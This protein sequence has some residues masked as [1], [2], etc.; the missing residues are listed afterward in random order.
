M[1]LFVRTLAGR[2]VEVQALPSDTI[3]ELKRKIQ[4]KE[5]IPSDQQR[6]I[7]TG[8]SLQDGYTL[9]EYN[10]QKESTLHM[11]LRLRGGYSLTGLSFSDVSNPSNVRKVAFTSTAPPGRK[12]YWGTNLECR[13]VCTPGYLVICRQDFGSLDVSTASFKCPNCFRSDQLIPVTVGF[14]NCK[15]RFRG[16]KASGEKSISEWVTV[17]KADL[18]QLFDSNPQTVWYRLTIES[19]SL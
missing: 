5:G 10:I 4:D 14:V 12:A 16:T 1:Q 6:L 15:Y 2:T 17:A 13:C 9:S 11:V 7:F 8:K 18:Y 19:A 3:D